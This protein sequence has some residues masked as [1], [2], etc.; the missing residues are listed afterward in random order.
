VTRIA[1]LEERLTALIIS[2]NNKLSQESH[3]M[4]QESLRLI[5]ELKSPTAASPSTSALG[6]QQF[7]I[8]NAAGSWKR[9]DRQGTAILTS[10]LAGHLIDIKTEAEVV[11]WFTPYMKEIVACASL[12][13]KSPL[14]L[15]NTER[16]A[17]VEDKHFMGRPSA[18]DMLVT[19]PAFF[20][21]IRTNADI[22]TNAHGPNPNGFLFGKLAH[23]DLRDA[24]EVIVEWKLDIG[25]N[26][27][28][29]LGEGIEYARRIMHIANEDRHCPLDESKVSIT[30]VI[31]ADRKGFQLVVCMGGCAC[32]CV[33]GKW[34]D[35]G[36]KDTLIEFIAA[37]QDRKSVNAIDQLCKKFSCEVVT[38]T[39]E[40][41]C[42]LGRGS[43]GRVF[44]VSR[45]QQKGSGSQQFALKVALGELGCSRIRDEVDNFT[46]LFDTLN[47]LSCVVTMVSSHIESNK[48]FAG[49]LL[50]PVGE[51]LPRTK[52]AILAAI[53]GLKQL[54]MK[55]LYHGDARL[56]N[57]VWLN[58]KALW[59]DFRTMIHVSLQPGDSFIADV[60][61]FVESFH[62]SVNMEVIEKEAK[63]YFTGVSSSFNSTSDDC[64]SSMWSKP[65]GTGP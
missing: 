10:E 59:L 45:V 27:F 52:H 17:W 55:G 5:Q 31:I 9:M 36:S 46:K 12:I 22:Q 41:R 4:S 24:I 44:R 60:K 8:L 20:R 53:D 35:T 1:D 30:R 32:E 23:W 29:G 63:K 14:A 3:K 54:A 7:D 42:F 34:S 33:V 15:V 40:S 57:V 47:E 25:Q 43:T 51:E 6:R 48:A 58:N 16:H 62:V 2:G 49:L 26:D 37:K 11:R 64:I 19:H 28:S 13:I 18:P 65:S 56:P 38:P 21:F 61:M 39:Q 50:G